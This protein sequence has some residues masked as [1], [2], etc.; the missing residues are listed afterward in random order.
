M[1]FLAKGKTERI[2]EDSDEKIKNLLKTFRHNLQNKYN[3]Y[4]FIFFSLEVS[5]LEENTE[6][7][8]TYSY[9]SYRQNYFSFP[10]PKL[11][12]DTASDLRD[13]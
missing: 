3:R 7:T 1:K 5:R 4:A 6:Y 10:V 11:R 8:C 12:I 2:I 9:V 13:E